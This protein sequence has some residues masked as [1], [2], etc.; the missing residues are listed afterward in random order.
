MTTPENQ[1]NLR[2]RHPDFQVFLDFNERESRRVEEAYPCHLD[3]KYGPEALQS[4]DI[5]PAAGENSPILVFIHGGYWKALDKSSYRFIAAPYVENGISVFLL[6]YRLIPPVNMQM[7][8]HDIRAGIE[9]I[10]SNARDYHANPDSIVLAGH[11]AGGHLALMAYLMNKHLRQSITAICSL[12]GIFDLKDIRHSY[13]NDVLQLD[14][15][16]VEAFSVSNKDLS[17]LNCPTLLSVGLDETDLFIEQSKA[18]Y[19]QHQSLAPLSYHE[20]P[21]LNHYQIVHT[22][23]QEDSP[24]TQFILKQTLS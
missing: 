12:S 23:G 18:L 15:S 21:N 3:I 8:L 6:N 5:F 14:Q 9:W 4:L 16:D 24:L 1:L 11:S 22:L 7:L 20:Y 17:L 19:T 13:L 2:A 10:H